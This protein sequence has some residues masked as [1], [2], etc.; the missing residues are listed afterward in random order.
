MPSSSGSARSTTGYCATAGDYHVELRRYQ[1]QWEYQV[2][3]L[4]KS[5]VL[6]EGLVPQLEQCRAEAVSAA[7]QIDPPANWDALEW[8]PL[9]AGK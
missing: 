5:E 3:S 7:K 8:K 1:D 2:I 4:K 6:K 9:Q